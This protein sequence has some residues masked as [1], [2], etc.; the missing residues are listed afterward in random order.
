MLHPRRQQKLTR[1]SA[2]EWPC[3]GGLIPNSESY[4]AFRDSA[5]KFVLSLDFK[6]S[7]MAASLTPGSSRCQKERRLKEE[8]NS[9]LRGFFFLL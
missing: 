1:A 2:E 7:R 3:G 4:A 6:T 5:N 9:A 8:K